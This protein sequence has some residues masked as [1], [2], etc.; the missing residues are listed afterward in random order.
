KEGRRCPRCNR[1]PEKRQ[2]AAKRG[3]GRRW[4]VASRAFLARPENRI[5]AI[6]KNRLAECVDHIVDHHGDMDLFWR[7]SNWQPACLACN[8]RKAHQR[9]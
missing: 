3:Y 4:R 9:E 1:P 2:S 8:T 7:I 6:C 5:C